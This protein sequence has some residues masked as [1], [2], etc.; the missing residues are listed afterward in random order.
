MHSPWR[1][2]AVKADF[3]AD[4]PDAANLSLSRRALT[5]L[6]GAIGSSRSL[7]PLNSSYCFAPGE[8]LFMS[9][10]IVIFPAPPRMP[11]MAFCMA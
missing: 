1:E 3:W 7:S 11:L 9:R 5:E 6:H 10:F 4:L 2:K 8:T